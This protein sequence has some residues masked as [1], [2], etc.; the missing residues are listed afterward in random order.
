[1]HL[2]F[3]LVKRWVMGTLHGS[4][5][6][7]HMPAY[8]DEW[9]FR[10]NR[11]NSRSRGLLFQ[12]LLQQAVEGDAL[13]D[14]ELRKAGRTRPPPPP[15]DRERMRP[16]SLEREDSGLPCGA[17][18]KPKHSH[19]LRQRDGDP[20]HRKQRIAAV[21][22]NDHHVTTTTSSPPMTPTSSNNATVNNLDAIRDEATG[23][24]VS[25]T[26]VAEIPFTAFASA[27]ASE[28]VPGRLVVRRI[29][30]AG[31]PAGPDQASL[32]AVWRFHAFHAT[33]PEDQMDT[34][35][36]AKTHRGHAIIEQ[37]F[38]ASRAPPSP[39]CHPGGSTPPPRGSSS[40]S[41]HSPRAR[42]AGTIAS[43]ARTRATFATIR[44]R[45]SGL[46]ARLATSVRRITTH[47][48]TAWPCNS[49]QAIFNATLGPPALATT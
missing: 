19:R 1:M 15:P 11:R 16:P 34:V 23:L 21:T 26:E 35:A 14:N 39:T 44:R 9:V 47:L 48:P 4:I 10:F 5:S 22:N 2:V 43:G 45:I 49:W 25:R 30:D 32:F 28:Q 42:A 37:V 41:S 29:P 3:S 18:S 33:V 46:P 40:R 38:D 13:T 6:P 27:K 17:T 8:F 36:A 20:T 12:R 31:A 24:W 7:E